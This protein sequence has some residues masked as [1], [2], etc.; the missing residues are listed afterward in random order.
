MR[1]PLLRSTGILSALFHEGAVVCEGDSDRAFY[2]EINY[3]LLTAQS[4]QT[5]DDS[6]NEESEGREEPEGADNTIFLAAQNKSTIQKIVWPMRAMGIPSVA[7]VDIDVFKESST[8]KTLLQAA[9]VPQASINV[10]GAHRGE[11]HRKLETKNREYQKGGL[12]L[13]EPADRE[14]AETLLDNLA[15]Y[16]IFVVPV[17]DL[18]RW[19]GCWLAELDERPRKSDYVPRVFE[20]MGSDPTDSSYLKPQDG[21]V[22]DFMRKVSAWIADPNR[23]GMPE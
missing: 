6:E 17:G 16:G 1:D 4:E 21:D 13:L 22:W 20:L 12:D 11:L 8:F 23:R 9:F 19:F 3:R 5:Q 15:A 7:I 10:W 18:E 2:Q 14:S